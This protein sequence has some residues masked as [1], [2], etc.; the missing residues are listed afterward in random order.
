VRIAHA[1]DECP[2]SNLGVAIVADAAI[3]AE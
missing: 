3:E 1:T 2:E